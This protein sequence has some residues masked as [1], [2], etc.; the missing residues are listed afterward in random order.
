M[1]RYELPPLR[2]TKGGARVSAAHDL[3]EG[4]G[5]AR[6]EFNKGRNSLSSVIRHE[7]GR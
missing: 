1:R 7:Y 3:V 6:K 5:L 2:R 4:F